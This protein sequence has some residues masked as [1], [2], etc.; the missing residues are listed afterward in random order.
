METAEFQLRVLKTFSD[1]LSRQIHEAVAIRRYQE[2]TLN[3]KAEFNSMDSTVT[4][5]IQNIE[6]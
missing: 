2:E 1:P 3:S 6:L 5:S 4:S